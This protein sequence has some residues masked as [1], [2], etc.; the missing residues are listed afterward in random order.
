MFRTE[1][2][3]GVFVENWA[4]ERSLANDQPKAQIFNFILGNQIFRQYGIA[5]VPGSFLNR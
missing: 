2:F 3:K 5:A 4:K 1:Q